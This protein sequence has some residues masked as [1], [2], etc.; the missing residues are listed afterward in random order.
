VV[1]S[2]GARTVVVLCGVVVRERYGAGPE[3]HPAKTVR[4]ILDECFEHNDDLRANGRL[5]AE[6]AL[7]PRETA[8]TLYWKNGKGATTQKGVNGVS[9]RI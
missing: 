2:N 5:V 9:W 7:Q 1:A 6:V 4:G 3:Y 8:V